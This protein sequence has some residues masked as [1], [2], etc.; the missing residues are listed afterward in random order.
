M[1]KFDQRMPHQ[2]AFVGNTPVSA[3]A[4]FKRKT[5]T[6]NTANVYPLSYNWYFRNDTESSGS[7]RSDHHNNAAGGH[8][9][10]RADLKGKSVPAVLLGF[11]Q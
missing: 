9:F 4:V 3:A 8:L 7:F 6:R 1:P 11:N 10:F 5:V 2:Q